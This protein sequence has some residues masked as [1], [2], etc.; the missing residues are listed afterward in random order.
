MKYLNRMESNS[1]NQIIYLMGIFLVTSPMYWFLGVPI[2]IFS[3]FKIS[4]LISLF[5]IFFIKSMFAQAP[6]MYKNDVT[7]IVIMIFFVVFSTLFSEHAKPSTLFFITYP[8]VYYLVLGL[9]FNGLFYFV[10][11]K[12]INTVLPNVVIKGIF[13]ICIIIVLFYIAGVEVK[14]PGSEISIAE[15]GFSLLRTGWSGSLSVFIAFICYHLEKKYLCLT[16]FIIGTIM[17]IILTQYISGG[18]GGLLTTFAILLCTFLRFNINSVFIIFAIFVS[19]VI[20]VIN[21]GLDEFYVHL[22]LDRGI[23]GEYGGISAGRFEQYYHGVKYMLDNAFLPSGYFGYAEYFRSQ[24]IFYE[25]HNVFLNLTVQYGIIFI[26]LFF[27]FIFSPLKNNP[28]SRDKFILY[29]G[30]ISCLFEPSA[31]FVNVNAYLCWWYIFY[32]AKYNQVN[33][34]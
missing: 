23:S 12:Q 32:H 10:D 24:G 3:L 22:R 14:A 9:I 26:V 34:T 28:F 30:L 17:L 7:I 18:R 25:I 5:S 13:L 8:F 21:I 31:I 20:Y 11:Y 4:L 16:P 2:T 27:V 19:S 1:N 6:I 15:T 33:I 29:L